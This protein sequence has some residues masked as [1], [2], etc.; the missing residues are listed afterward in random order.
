MAKVKNYYA[1]T[2]SSIGF[3]S[4]YDEALKGLDT[5]Y[6]LKG[7]PGTGK[8][9]F[10]RKIGLIYMDKGYDLEYLH[11][12]S[13]NQS[14]DGIVIPELK[15]GFV[16]GTAPHV[17]EP[18]Y[19]GVVEKVIDLGQY[20]NDGYLKQYKSQIIELTDDI[21]K[22]FEN[23]YNTFA[24]AKKVHLKREEIYISSMSFKKA[25]GVVQNLIDTIFNKPFDAEEN[26]TNRKRFFGAATPKGA[27]NFI[28]NITEEYDKRYIIKGRPGSGKSTLMKKIAKHAEQHGLSVEYFHCAF[29]PKS[30][31]MIIIPKLSVSIVDGTAPHVVDPFRE[32][33]EVVDMFALC[34]DPKIESTFKKEIEE[35]NLEYKN[36]MT[37]GTNFLSEAKRLHDKLEEYYKAAMDFEAID[38]KREELVKTL[39]EE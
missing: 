35:L 30:I 10:M 39:L 6:I 31:D 32:Q 19:P 18:K 28:D 17:I 16:D 7:G 37:I 36:K 24:E 15:L 9:T 13:D 8:S 34:M 23:A 12:S 11:C 5:L 29:D 27:V 3:Y 38:K 4:L 2:N 26:P 33:D 21:S 1:G 22:N 14:I 25:D 20:R